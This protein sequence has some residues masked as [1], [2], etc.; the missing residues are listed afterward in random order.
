MDWLESQLSGAQNGGKF[1]ITY[2]IYPGAKYKSIAKANW[3]E[4]YSN[5]YFKI[6]RKHHDKIVME[7]G[8]HDHF[9]DLRYHSNKDA[10]YFYHN[11]LISPGVTPITKQNPG[12]AT[13]DIDLTMTPTNLTM[14]FLDLDKTYGMKSAPTDIKDVPI[15]VLKF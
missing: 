10:P 8:A 12:F 15:N 1:I 9:S 2:H 4:T 7:I 14:T 13:F 6:I 5:A 3:I 11:I